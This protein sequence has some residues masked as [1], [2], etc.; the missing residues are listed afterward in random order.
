MAYSAVCEKS[1][2]VKTASRMNVR[3]VLTGERYSI[4][5]DSD[6]FMVINPFLKFSTESPPLTVV[7]NFSK[8]PKL[9]LFFVCNNSNTFLRVAAAELTAAAAAIAAKR[10]LLTVKSDVRRFW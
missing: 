7:N 10:R 2:N 9:L 3:I 4:L 1:V 5:I 8:R 6:G